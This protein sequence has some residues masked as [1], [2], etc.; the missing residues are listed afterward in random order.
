MIHFSILKAQ[1]ISEDSVI[2]NLSY[3]IKTNLE[4]AIFFLFLLPP[5]G[6]LKLGIHLYLVD[7]LL[8]SMS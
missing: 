2:Y 3:L 4:H 1:K 7:D 8:H 6:T 5:H